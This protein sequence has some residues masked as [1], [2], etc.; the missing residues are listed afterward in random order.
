MPF[1]FGA[2][3]VGT[4]ASGALGYLGAEKSAKAQENAANTASNT[5][6][7]MYGQTRADLQPYQQAGTNALPFLQQLYGIG[8]GSTGATSPILAALGIGPGGQPGTATTPFQQSP[9]YQFAKQ[10]GIGAATNATAGK[11]GMGGNT[12]KALSQFG[13]GIANQ[14]YYSYLAAL[15]SAWGGLTGG[16]GNLVGLGE[17]AAAKTGQ[18]GAQTASDV[19]GYQIGAGNAAAA[20]IM[21]QTNALTGAVNNLTQ[22]ATTLYNSPGG[23]FPLLN[24]GG[25]GYVDSGSFLA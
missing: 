22:G 25:S 12:L 11:G 15:Q 24:G 20:G 13:T 21:G 10:Q 16:V 19:G 23:L 6:L 4:V 2:L 3:A 17:S 9:G 18:I 14:D 7:Q 8:P 1:G 5:E